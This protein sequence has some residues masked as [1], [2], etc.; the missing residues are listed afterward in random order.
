MEPGGHTHIDH[1]LT[2]TLPPR[3]DDLLRYFVPLTKINLV[4]AGM[5]AGIVTEVYAAFLCCLAEV[6]GS[7]Y[8]NKN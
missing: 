7:G 4:N 2:Q 3:V 5:N 6:K 8:Q 1:E